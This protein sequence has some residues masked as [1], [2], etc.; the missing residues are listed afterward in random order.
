M[1]CICTLTCPAASPVISA[2]DA[3]SQSSRYMSMICRSFFGIRLIRS[4]QPPKRGFVRRY[5]LLVDIVLSRLLGLRLIHVPVGRTSRLLVL[6]SK[7]VA[8]SGI[9]L[10]GWRRAV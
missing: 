10:Q 7:V 2:I 3:A 9:A 6:V 4:R 5:C 8:E 1:R